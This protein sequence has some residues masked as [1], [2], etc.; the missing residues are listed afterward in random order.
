MENKKMF[1]ENL[2]D[3]KCPRCSALLETSMRTGTH[4]CS[5]QGCEFRVNDVRFQ[6][7]IS[8]KRPRKR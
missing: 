5:T 2:K 1:W 8:D 6:E 3:N 4:W 7:L